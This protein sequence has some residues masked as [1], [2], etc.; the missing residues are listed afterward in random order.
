MQSLADRLHGFAAALF[1]PALV[2]PPGLVGPDGQPSPKRFSVYRNNVVVGLIGALKANFPAV[3]RIVG[4][5]FFD[6]MARIFVV[7]EPPTSPILL[8]YGAGFADFI[9]G[10][11]PAASLPY[12]PDVARLERAWLESYHAAEAIPLTPEALAAIPG[13]RAADLTFSVHPSLRLIWSRFPVLTIWQMNVGDGVPGPVDLTAG[14]EDVLVM[15]PAGEVEVRAMPPGGYEFVEALQ[16][17]HSLTDAMK[18]ALHADPR[19]D[20]SGNIRDLITAGVFVECY[21]NDESELQKQG[22]RP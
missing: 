11:E 5:E 15:R 21:L 8:H 17:G 6:A 7:S 12:L 9:A 1:D 20:L 18:V 16:Q 2:A 14:G 10:F 13:D 3:C 19:F 22:A 4:E